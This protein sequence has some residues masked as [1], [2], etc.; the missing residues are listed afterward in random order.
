VIAADGV[1]VGVV[2]AARVGVVVLGHGEGALTGLI[3]VGV[4]EVLEPVETELMRLEGSVL[5][6]NGGAGS[7]RVHDV[8]EA[9]ERGEV[10]LAHGG[11]GDGLEDAVAD[12][13]AG[14]AV[15]AEDE[16][17]VAAVVD[18][19]DRRRDR[20]RWWRTCCGW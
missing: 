1:D 7:E 6:G 11:G 3:G 19:G 15:G 14:A 10:A 13:V 12:A 20:R 8:D 9:G 18:F 17:L 5:L 2:G 16:G 4:D